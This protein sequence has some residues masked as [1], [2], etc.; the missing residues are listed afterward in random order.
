[1][2]HQKPEAGKKH[3]EGQEDSVRTKMWLVAHW[4]TQRRVLKKVRFQ[5]KRETTGKEGKD[6]TMK[7]T[8]TR[9]LAEKKEKD[10]EQGAGKNIEGPQR[11]R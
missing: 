1:M 9:E 3:Q 10:G 8:I 2:E 4:R 11:K 5:K 6:K 7:R